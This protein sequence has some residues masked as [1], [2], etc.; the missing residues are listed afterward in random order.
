MRKLHKKQRCGS[1]NSSKH[2]HSQVETSLLISVR[3]Q[4]ISKEG[5]DCCKNNGKE[6]GGEKGRRALPMV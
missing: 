2:E 4:D 5:K 3:T 1:V 6:V